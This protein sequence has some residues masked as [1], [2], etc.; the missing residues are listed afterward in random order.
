MFHNQIVR[1]GVKSMGRGASAKYAKS[2]CC[3]ASCLLN[4]VTRRKH[5]DFPGWPGNPAD[6]QRKSGGG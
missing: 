6:A 3:M 5:E 2:S 1:L 4:Q